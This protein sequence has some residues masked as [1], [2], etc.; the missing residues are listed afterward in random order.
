MEKQTRKTKSRA[1]WYNCTIRLFGEMNRQA[2]QDET[3]NR[4]TQLG[5]KPMTKWKQRHEQNSIATIA[6]GT[7]TQTNIHITMHLFC[8]FHRMEVWGDGEAMSINV[9]H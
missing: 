5:N 7:K 2:Q 4:C 1:S 6:M 8:I 3:R 9:I